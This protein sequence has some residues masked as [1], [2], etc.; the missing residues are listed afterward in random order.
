MT[1]K[2]NVLKIY[3]HAH[4]REDDYFYVYVYHEPC[5]TSFCCSEP[6]WENRFVGPVTTSVGRAWRKAWKEIQLM[7]LDKLEDYDK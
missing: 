2:E 6:S 1:A 4:I 7:M 5:K 3:K